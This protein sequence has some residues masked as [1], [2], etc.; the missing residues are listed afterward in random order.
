MI[1]EM[2]KP[3]KDIH[4]VT[5]KEWNGRDK[6]VQNLKVETRVNKGNPNWENLEIKLGTGTTESSHTNREQR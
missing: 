2:K 6:T 1:E 5:N 4:E 3:L